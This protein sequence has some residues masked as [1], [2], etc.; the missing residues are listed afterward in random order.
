MMPFARPKEIPRLNLDN[1]PEYE[2]T[3]EEEEGE[4]QENQ[5]QAQQDEVTHESSALKNLSQDQAT[6]AGGGPREH[7]S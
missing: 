3:S 2:T 1:L 4:L 6:A 7:M 5:D